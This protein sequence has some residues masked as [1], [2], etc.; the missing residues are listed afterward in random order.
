M[1]TFRYIWRCCHPTHT[2]SCWLVPASDQHSCAHWQHNGLG[3]VLLLIPTLF[4]RTHFMSN[5]WP[6]SPFLWA[7]LTLLLQPQAVYFLLQ[8]Q[9]SRTFVCDGTILCEPT[10]ILQLSN[11]LGIFYLHSHLRSLL[12]VHVLPQ[13]APSRTEIGNQVYSSNEPSSSAPTDT[14]IHMPYNSTAC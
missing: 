13:R 1:L 14:C 2:C 10:H 8:S 11:I 5:W 12:A 9:L 6:L 7:C 4:M 3:T